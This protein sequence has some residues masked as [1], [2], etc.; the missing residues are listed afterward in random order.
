MALAPGYG[1]LVLGRIVTGLGVGV[2][3]V[4]VPVYISEITPSEYR[5]MLS[6]CFDVSINVGILL[7]YVTGFL[8]TELG[9]GRLS[10][11]ATWRLMLA[12]G[13]LLPVGVMVAMAWL[14]ESPRWLMARGRPE[15]ARAVL[16]TFLGDADLAGETIVSIKRTMD[17]DAGL[18]VET[19]AGGGG[20]G[21]GALPLTWRELLRLDALP[22]PA[23]GYLL[24]V[25]ATVVGLGFW[26][27][28]TGSEA[29]LYYSAT[30]LEE[31]GLTSARQRLLGY[32]ALG[33]CKVTR[34]R[35]AG[36]RTDSGRALRK[37]ARSLHAHLLPP[38]GGAA[39]PALS[40]CPRPW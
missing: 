24:R 17:E 1:T 9:G 36:D 26:Q 16:T 35:Q 13:G 15:Q 39:L 38:P 22:N 11:E 21:G 29:V 2:S 27:Q 5:G 34:A 14:P 37:A 12:L 32:V 10:D 20:R 6:T 40:S 3:F 31:A 23:D 19:P 8:V 28:A 7:G 18:L 4:V 33:C 25:V 30:F